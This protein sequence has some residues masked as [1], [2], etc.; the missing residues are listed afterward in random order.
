MSLKHAAG[1]NLVR[2][3]GAMGLY[4]AGKLDSTAYTNILKRT[5][6]AA[7]QIDESVQNNSSTKP[8]EE[9]GTRAQ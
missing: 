2:A 5:L 7:N 3:Y 6:P 1:L 8:V 4:K 9:G